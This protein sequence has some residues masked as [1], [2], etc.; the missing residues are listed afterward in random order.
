[1]LACI[2]YN[3]VR[4]NYV[5]MVN[6]PELL[7]YQKKNDPIAQ[8]IIKKNSDSYSLSFP[9]KNSKFNYSTSF[10]DI[11]DLKTYIENNF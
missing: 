4:N 6:K 10:A 7:I 9:L 5:E 11:Q 2:E 8:L 3:L 1:M